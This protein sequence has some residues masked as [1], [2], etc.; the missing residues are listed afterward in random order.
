MDE[1]I[2]ANRARWDELAALHPDAPDYRTAEF[3]AGAS[4]LHQIDRDEVGPVAGKTLLHLQCHFG[5]DTLSWAREGAVVTGFDFAPR[6]IEEARKLSEETGIPGRF[7]LSTYDQLEADLAGEQ[8]DIVYMSRGTLCWLPDIAKVFGVAARLLKPGGAFHLID[9]HPFQSL[10]DDKHPWP[11]P[12]APRLV[13]SYFYTP[14]PT[15][16]ESA[17][18]YADADAR[19]ANTATYE[20]NHDLGEIVNAVIGAGLRLE[21]LREYPYTYWRVLPSMSEDEDHHWHLPPELDGRL[22]LMF[23]LKA[24]K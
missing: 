7:V 1:F 24:V 11:A 20:W 17:V 19:L 3:K 15:R 22:P 4:K 21:R 8:F 12:D 23:S 14:E 13:W 9:S 18:S 5:L 16:W 10:L 2:A 6:A